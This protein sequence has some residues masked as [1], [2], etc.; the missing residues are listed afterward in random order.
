MRPRPRGGCYCSRC[1]VFGL[2]G[3]RGGGGGAEEE[4]E[5]RTRGAGGGNGGTGAG[6]GGGLAEASAGEKEA[7]ATAGCGRRHGLGKVWLPSQGDPGSNADLPPLAGQC[8][9]HL[10]IILIGLLC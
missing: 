7:S 9:S 4:G 5:G 6:A 8:E 1:R 10:L 3:R 2:G